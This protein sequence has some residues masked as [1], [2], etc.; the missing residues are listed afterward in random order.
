MQYA[1]AIIAWCGNDSTG[2]MPGI[3]FSR[4]PVSISA[5]QTAMIFLCICLAQV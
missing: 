1:G 2:A 3:G 4:Q 5:C